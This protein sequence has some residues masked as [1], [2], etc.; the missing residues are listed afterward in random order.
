MSLDMQPWVLVISYK[1]SSDSRQN[2]WTHP[3]KKA[4]ITL[5]YNTLVYTNAKKKVERQKLVEQLS[6]EEA[7]TQENMKM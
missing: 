7:T 3:E 5:I 4:S 6:H 1:N 2:W